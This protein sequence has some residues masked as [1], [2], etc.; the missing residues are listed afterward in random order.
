M[1]CLSLMY[2]SVIIIS[3]EIH[4][5]YLRQQMQGKEIVSEGQKLKNSLTHGV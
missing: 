5:L 2:N 1:L 4:E 3:Q